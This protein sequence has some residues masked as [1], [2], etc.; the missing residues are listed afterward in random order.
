MNTSWESPR[1]ARHS[2]D[3]GADGHVDQIAEGFFVD[4]VLAWFSVDDD[5]DGRPD[6]IMH[7]RFDGDALVRVAF[8]EN[9]D[10]VIDRVE[11]PFFQYYCFNVDELRNRDLGWGYPYH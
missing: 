7:Y 10:G 4:G 1:R 8:D 2:V 5:A 11:D 9:A 3:F 6:R